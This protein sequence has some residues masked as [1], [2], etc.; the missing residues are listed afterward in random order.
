MEQSAYADVPFQML[1]AEL[2]A[3]RRANLPLFRR[4]DGDRWSARGE[5]SGMPITVRGLAYIMVGH[6]RHHVAVL[7]ERYALTLD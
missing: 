1:V 4:L 7:K 2:G 6:I 5:A 3:L